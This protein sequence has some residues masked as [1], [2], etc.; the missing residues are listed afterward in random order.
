MNKVPKISCADWLITI[1]IFLTLQCCICTEIIGGRKVNPHSRPYMVSIQSHKKHV[2]GGA[3]IARRW[4]LTA[5]HCES[6]VQKQKSRVVLGA[7]SLSK[8]Q[9]GKKAIPVRKMIPHPKFNSR[10]PENDIMLVELARE[11]I[12]NKYVS[13]LKLP[14]STDDVKAGTKCSVAGW[15]T[16]DSSVLKASDV[17]REVNLIVI[18]RSVCNSK[19]YYNLSPVITKDMLC[20]GD[21][22]AR[23]DSCAGDSGGPLICMKKG[24]KKE[25]TGIVSAGAECGTPNEPGIYTRLSE[26]Y[27]EW[28]KRITKIENQNVTKD[29]IYH[30]EEIIGG[31]DAKPHSKPYMASLQR[32][33]NQKYEHLCG[34]ALIRRDWVLTAA[35]CEIPLKYITANQPPQVVLGVHNLSAKERSQQRLYVRKWFPHPEYKRQTYENDIMLVQLKGEATLNKF[36]DILNL[37]NSGKDVKGGDICNVAGWGI[38]SI[39]R[40]KAKVLQEVN[41]T[42]VDRNLCAEYYTYH[43]A[44]TQ[45]VLCAGDKK[46]G[47]DSCNGDS[48]GPLLCHGNFN[49]IVSFGCNCGIPRKPGV[50]T[51]LS[52]KYLSW[53]MKIISNSSFQ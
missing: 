6:W 12:V 27:L 23:K 4:V 26:K 39:K 34:G 21:D 14:E 24:N 30:G 8:K 3:L 40:E 52:E 5:A 17:L 18:D 36:V 31:R 9:Q 1:V 38:T 45:N 2:C 22:E 47:K 51:R 53:I 15:G 44:I 35:H 29:E 13:T 25:Y 32:F 46:G 49:G 28:I 11:A 20:V 33:S 7:D 16:T 42:V 48:G 10:T 43:P 37:P 19:A 41:V 50:Y